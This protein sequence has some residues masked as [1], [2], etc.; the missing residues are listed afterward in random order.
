MW[1][2]RSCRDGFPKR[3]AGL[4]R[5]VRE[6]LREPAYLASLRQIGEGSKV[7]YLTPD[8][9]WRTALDS[10]AEIR[11]ILRRDPHAF[12]SSAQ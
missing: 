6:V 9:L 12:G 8:Q 5:A 7:E 4:V 1:A 10:D 2:P 11:A 3:Y